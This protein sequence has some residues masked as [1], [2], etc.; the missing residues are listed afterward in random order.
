MLEPWDRYLTRV[1][2][3]A[4]TF[5]NAVFCLESAAA[6]L[7][8]PLFG[9]ARDVHLL[10]PGGVS[11]RYSDV[12]IHSYTCS[13]EI[14]DLNGICT[15]GLLETA[16]QLC[17]IVPPA[18]ALAIADAVL[19]RLSAEGMT[20]NLSDLAE[21]AATSRGQRQLRWVAQR[22]TPIAESVGESV[23]RAAIEW[24][25]YPFP[26][27]QVTLT[28]EGH[29]DRVDFRWRAHRIVGESDG[30]GKYDASNVAA[31]RQL[32]VNEKLREDRIRRYER[33]F[34]RWGWSDTMRPDRLD[35]KLRSAGLTPVR[36]QQK[37]LLDTL[38]TNPR[39]LP[40]S[41]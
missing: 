23:S 25:G 41:H 34:A 17:R 18:F 13:D 1:H 31:T 39:S 7:G 8:L 22:A 20:A 3:V 33:G 15:T 10:V 11:R 40:G 30:Y 38:R 32:F 35:N 27:L 14:V 26:E 9:Q 16:T 36:P 28:H 24:L 12:V 5:P 37:A 6:L 4:L 2:G 29:N 19:R 21:R